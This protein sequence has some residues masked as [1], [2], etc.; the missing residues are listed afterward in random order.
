MSVVIVERLT[1]RRALDYYLVDGYD[2]CWDEANDK[3]DT[4]IA[5]RESKRQLYWDAAESTVENHTKL[6]VDGRIR[7]AAIYMMFETLCDGKNRS[8][9]FHSSGALHLLKRNSFLVS[10][11]SD[12][13][14]M[15]EMKK[16]HKG[17][18]ERVEEQRGKILSGQRVW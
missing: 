15:D 16:E 7:N 1:F 17:L 3:S 2:P 13:A 14:T 4:T 11:N 12:N 18:K 6:G 9:A 10:N 8:D 5:L